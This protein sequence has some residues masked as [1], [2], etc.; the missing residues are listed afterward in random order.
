M[1][2]RDRADA[3]VKL[4]AAFPAADRCAGSELHGCGFGVKVSRV[5]SIKTP[6]QIYEKFIEFEERAASVYVRLASHFSKNPEL[7]SFWLDMGMQ[8]KQHA[9]LLQFLLAEKLFAGNLPDDSTIQ[10]VDGAFRDFESRAVDP[11][12]S[13]PSAFQIALEMESSEV[14]DIYSHLTS[15]THTSTYLWH[16]QISTLAPGHI[17]YLADSARKFGAGDDVIQKLDL[18]KNSCA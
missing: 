2:F 17:G 13:I 16:R 10:K 3:G 7:G 1:I 12:L 18:L 14:N 15:T 9:G 5:M 11:E 4:A 6:G 8:E